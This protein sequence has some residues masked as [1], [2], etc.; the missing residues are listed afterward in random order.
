M[1]DILQEEFLSYNEKIYLLMNLRFLNIMI[2]IYQMNYIFFD[3][4]LAFFLENLFFF[5]SDYS[6]SNSFL[7][8]HL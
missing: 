1:N 4:S 7:L 8:F 2:K 6:L 5:H 3:L